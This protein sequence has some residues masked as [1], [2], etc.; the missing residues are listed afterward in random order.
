MIKGGPKREAFGKENVEPI[1]FSKDDPFWD[2]SPMLNL[3]E[4]EARAGEMD[5]LLILKR[6]KKGIMS[7]WRG[8]ESLSI[9][10]GM[11]SY[12]QLS[13]YADHVLMKDD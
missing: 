7:Y 5:T 6:S 10:L 2:L 11:L 12:G 4:K 3:I 9:V 1:S 13:L 8:T